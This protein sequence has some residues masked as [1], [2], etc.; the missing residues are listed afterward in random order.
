MNARVRDHGCQLQSIVGGLLHELTREAGAQIE[1]L[2]WQ[3][4]LIEEHRTG[5]AGDPAHAEH[6][7]DVLPA[8]L[9]LAAVALAAA[10]LLL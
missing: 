1:E 10:T 6:R 3:C 9:L 8:G 2:R 5:S 4:T 7:V